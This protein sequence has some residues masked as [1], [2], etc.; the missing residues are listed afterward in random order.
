[1]TGQPAPTDLESKSVNYTFRWPEGPTNVILTGEFD[2]W[3]A[4]LPLDKTARGDFCVTYPLIFSERD[5]IYFKF[6]VDGEW[7]V[8]SAYPTEYGSDGIENNYIT[9]ADALKARSEAAK[10]ET[11]DVRKGETLDK[12]VDSNPESDTR[13]SDSAQD[14]HI[15]P[16]DQSPVNGFADG[17]VNPVLAGLGPVIPAHPE[18]IEA[19]A[20]PKADNETR[21]E[22]LTEHSDT[23][24]DLHADTGNINKRSPVKLNQ[25]ESNDGMKMKEVDEADELKKSPGSARQ[26]SP[27]KE[28]TPFETAREDMSV[29]DLT[30]LDIPELAEGSPDGEHAKI[31]GGKSI[32]RPEWTKTPSGDEQREVQLVPEVSGKAEPVVSATCATVTAAA[33]GT[34]NLSEVKEQSREKKLR[35]KKA[36]TSSKVSPGSNVQEDTGDDKKKKKKR[37]L[38]SRL[39]KFLT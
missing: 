23:K 17:S 38:F 27:M 12:T 39:K 32:K 13:F 8:N 16:V 22:G 34:P 24:I 36:G 14:V 9:L 28:G 6:I 37:G 21:K 26:T 31:S 29:Q 15:L 33:P 35:N 3:Q 5:K 2:N 1:M 7:T 20:L 30:E 25:D 18:N 10:L 4:T 11:G 19:F